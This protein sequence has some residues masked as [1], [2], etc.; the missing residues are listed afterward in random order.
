MAF[1]TSQWLT[2][3]HYAFQVSITCSCVHVHCM[4]RSG[5]IDVVLQHIIMYTCTRAGTKV[6]K[7][8]S[9]LH[10]CFCWCCSYLFGYG[11]PPKLVYWFMTSTVLFLSLFLELASQ[12][13]EMKQKQPKLF[14]NTHTLLTTCLDCT[15]A[16]I[17]VGVAMKLRREKFEQR[18]KHSSPIT[19]T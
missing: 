17:K 16:N 15:C 4:H 9:K 2:H 14:W 3:L 5:N 11:K 18:F 12:E 10:V 1:S 8:H 6:T 7:Q 13:W 19:C